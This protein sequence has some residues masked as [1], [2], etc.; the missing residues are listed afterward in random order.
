MDNLPSPSRQEKKEQTAAWL[1][2]QERMANQ[3]GSPKRT[4]RTAGA[5]WP[6][7]PPNKVDN[8][9]LDKDRSRSNSRMHRD[10]RVRDQ[11]QDGQQRQSNLGQDPPQQNDPPGS[12]QTQGQAG[13]SSAP[14]GPWGRTR[15]DGRR[16]PILYF[17]RVDPDNELAT[18]AL[19]S[20]Q[21][22]KIHGDEMELHGLTFQGTTG[23]GLPY[24]A[25][26]TWDAHNNRRGI[27]RPNEASAEKIAS[28]VDMVKQFRW[29]VHPTW[30]FRLMTAKQAGSGL[31]CTINLPPKLSK[32][33]MTPAEQTERGILI[34]QSLMVQNPTLRIDN[35]RQW[36]EVRLFQ[37]PGSQTLQLKARITREVLTEMD[38]LFAGDGIGILFYANLK[39]T[40]HNRPA[41]MVDPRLPAYLN[42]VAA[43]A[44]RQADQ[45]QQ[46]E[47]RT[48]P[49]QQQGSGNGEP[50]VPEAA[51]APT[52][53][54]ADP[55]VGAP[56]LGI[57]P[58]PD[59]RVLEEVRQAIHIR[60]SAGTPAAGPEG[61][62]AANSQREAAASEAATTDQPMETSQ[63]RQD[64]VGDPMDSQESLD[65]AEWKVH[66][67]KRSR[68]TPTTP[69]ARQ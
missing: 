31:A 34:W 28:L 40:I 7:N 62:S 64:N 10:P 58:L 42:R 2:R 51:Q 33:G 6:N 11:N 65:M 55:P 1:N 5:G 9:Q 39:V 66:E 53:M 48:A 45:R 15:R 57:I 26:R 44:N 61:D 25:A 38:K 35:G 47:G 37:P 36:G 13:Q 49:P 23:R 41:D 12:Q 19:T 14:Q 52:P 54:A 32:T 67:G 69:P 4:S 20:D 8:N 59:P 63:S 46:E 17:H 22:T 24:V 50:A 18:K 68:R 60:P 21:F 29:S 56:S 16:G 43:E 30:R 27:Y 3:Y